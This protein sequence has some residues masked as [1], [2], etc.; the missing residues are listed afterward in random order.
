MALPIDSS[1][2]CKP[3]ASL[4]TSSTGRATVRTS[5]SSATC[6]IGDRIHDEPSI[7]SADSTASVRLAARGDL[8]AGSITRA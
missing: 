3:Q 2:F 6:S 7:F 5:S 8:V 1:G 4:T